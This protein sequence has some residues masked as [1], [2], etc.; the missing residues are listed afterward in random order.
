MY[1]IYLPSSSTVRTADAMVYAHERLYV[2]RYDQV[3]YQTCVHG[4]CHSS[5]DGMFTIPQRLMKLAHPQIPRLTLLD[6]NVIYFVTIL[7]HEIGLGLARHR[8]GT[9]EWQTTDKIWSFAAPSL[10]YCPSQQYL[11]IPYGIRS[12]YV[13]T[14]PLASFQPFI[15]GN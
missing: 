15:H 14:I 2:Q 12:D 5:P 9:D 1:D 8:L 3:L 11:V 6:D 10:F 7:N 13:L 4:K